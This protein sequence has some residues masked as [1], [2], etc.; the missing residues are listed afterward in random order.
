MTMVNQVSSMQPF[1]CFQQKT[2]F[3]ELS[4]FSEDDEDEN[5]SEFSASVF[6]EE[7]VAEIAD[8]EGSMKPLKVS[9]ESF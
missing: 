6:D 1:R 2:F 5:S 8:S 7:E 9:D 3:K 4:I